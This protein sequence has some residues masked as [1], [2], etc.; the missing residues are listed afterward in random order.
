MLDDLSS[1]SCRPEVLSWAA[2]VPF[3]GAIRESTVATV[4]INPSN[5]EFVDAKGNAL[6]PDDR[7]LP[8]LE[9]LAISY[10]SDATGSHIREVVMSCERYFE[11]NPYRQWFD[12]LERML[13][14][15]G[16]SYYSGA[17]ACHLD[18]VAFATRSKWG[19]LERD[20]QRAFVSQGRRALAEMIRD[21]PIQVLV[22][23][24]RSVLRVFEEFANAELVASEVP[25]WTLPRS[26]GKGVVGLAYSGVITSIAEIELDREVK[27]FG[28]NH[29]L[30]SSFGVTTEVMRSIGQQVGGAVASSN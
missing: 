7:R 16:Y 26:N 18:L 20:A 15:A 1:P 2:P 5:R 12:V 25:E 4:G 24:G 28:Y 11:G 9:S 19:T 27:I 13:K 21:S 29:N 14:V 8:T 6:G 30:Q 17:R 10:W 23:N 22:L 3:F